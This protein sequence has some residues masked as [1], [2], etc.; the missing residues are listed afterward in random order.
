MKN[1][2]LILLL[3]LA[4]KSSAQVA[5]NLTGDTAD[6]TAM[7]DV[8]STAKGLLVPRMTAAQRTAIITPAAGL[9]VYQTDSPIGFYYNGGTPQ[10][11]SWIILISANT[12]GTTQW[13]TVGNDI[14]YTAGKVGIGVSPA[15]P[16]HVFQSFGSASSAGY[17]SVAG[18][19]A[20]TGVEINNTST[21]ST[22]Y[23][24]KSTVTGSG[25]NR[26]IYGTATGGTDW[27]GYFD[28]GNVYVKDGLYINTTTANFRMNVNGFIGIPATNNYRYNT[29][30]T[31]KYKIGPASMT[32]ANPTVYD[33]R[34]DEGFSSATVNGL[35]SLSATGGTAGTVAYFLA[36]VNLPDSA[37]ITGLAAQLVKNGGSLQSIVELY[38]TD[39]TGYL[40][41]TAQLIGSC[42]TTGSGGGIAYVTAS[43]I[44]A[45]YNTV[46]NTNY[47]YFI[48]Y[49]GEQNTQ[50][51]RFVNATLTYQIYRSDY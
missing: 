13:N 49:S 22:K 48:R 14:S 7:L 30:K 11:P 25:E 6:S 43:S 27:A 24:L 46:D 8:K 4:V 44:N 45:A 5:V 16:L 37:V 20:N 38:R 42:T 32:S 50:N 10:S 51:L 2:L 31:K 35:N 3:V 18:A 34:I 19:G 9:L 29:A 28:D 36:P 26:A 41:N 17:F 39:G 12:G 21:G 1:S 15:Y 47:T 33:R 23:G 40:N